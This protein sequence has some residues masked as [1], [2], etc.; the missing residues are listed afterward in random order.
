MG[1]SIVKHIDVDRINPG[2][3]NRK[4][5]LLGGKI[6]DILNEIIDLNKKL[7]IQELLVHVGTNHVPYE[8]PDVVF[9]Q[10]MEMIKFLTDTM[11]D[12]KLYI[13]SILPKGMKSDPDYNMLPGILNINSRLYHMQNQSGFTLIS[14]NSFYMGS[15]AFD[16][17]LLSR[18]DVIHLNRKGQGRLARDFMFRHEY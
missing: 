7:D 18:N 9:G 17:S 2:G 4:K 5:A 13:S 1:D 12:T 14:H 8:S 3:H 10:L 15:R 6:S 16:T 11:P